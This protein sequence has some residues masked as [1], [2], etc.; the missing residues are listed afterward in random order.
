MMKALPKHAPAPP[1]PPTW[2][3]CSFLL[4]YWS[5]EMDLALVNLCWALSEVLAVPLPPLPPNPPV[6][7]VLPPPPPEEEEE[8]A[9]LELDP[10]LPKLA[11]LLEGLSTLSEELKA[12]CLPKKWLLEEEEE[13]LEV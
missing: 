4:K 13:V 3:S 1:P 5:E 10:M 2:L 9:L 8:E 6:F 7:Q 12:L 11:T